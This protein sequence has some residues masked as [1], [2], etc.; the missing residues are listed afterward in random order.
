M[1]KTDLLHSGEG[2]AV[3]GPICPCLAVPREEGDAGGG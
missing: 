3:P 2:Q 1:A